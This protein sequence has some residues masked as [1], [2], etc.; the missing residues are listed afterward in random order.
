[1]IQMAGNTTRSNINIRFIS[2]NVKGLNN[3]VKTK[4]VLSHLQSLKGDII[5][6]Q[7]THLRTLDVSRIKS[8]WISH[9]FHSKFGVKARGAA[10]L[11]HKNVAFEP[12]SV[13]SDS[14]GRYV[15][16]SGILQTIPVVL[17]CIYGPNWDN[18]TF[19]AHFFSVL[20][21][22]FFFFTRSPFIFTN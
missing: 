5:F 12:E 8:A 11:V 17:A 10:I 14:N 21:N 20:P 16:V 4:K 15:I 9:C 6:F 19:F 18:D 2:W 3:I 13:V 1:M 7:E 22:L